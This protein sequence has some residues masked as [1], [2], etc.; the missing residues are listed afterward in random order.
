MASSRL[1]E[2]GRLLLAH[3]LAHGMQQGNGVTAIQRSPDPNHDEEAARKALTDVIASIQREEDQTDDKEDVKDQST[4]SKSHRSPNLDR[5]LPGGATDDYIYADYHAAEA[6]MAKEDA[7]RRQKRE[8]ERARELDRAIDEYS[9]WKNGGEQVFEANMTVAQLEANQIGA[10]INGMTGT[11]SG[12][13]EEEEVEEAEAI[14]LG[15]PMIRPAGNPGQRAIGAPNRLAEDVETELPDPEKVVDARNPNLWKLAARAQDADRK[16]ADVT[17]IVRYAFQKKSP[18]GPGTPSN[19]N[20]PTQQQRLRQPA[21]VAI[22]KTGTD[23]AI[24]VPLDERSPS[25]PAIFNSAS[26]KS[27][28]APPKMTPSLAR[29]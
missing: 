12:V 14:A 4:R 3:E 8:A 1:L 16:P 27:T 13:E 25:T 21:Q 5:F 29:L 15:T 6:R 26:V 17:D 7:R 11:T 2:E 20:V 18:V 10:D 23:S 22:R 24:V 28:G 9:A 19:D